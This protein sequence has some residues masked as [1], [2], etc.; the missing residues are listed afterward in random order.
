M[1]LTGLLKLTNKVNYE[2]FN[3]YYFNFINQFT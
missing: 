3:I 1:I 2:T